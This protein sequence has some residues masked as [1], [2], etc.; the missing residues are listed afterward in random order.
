MPKNMR[1][2]KQILWAL[3]LLLL[4]F[5]ACKE[6]F[7]YKESRPLS[8]NG[9]TYRDT[10]DYQFNITDTS[11]LYNLYLVFEHADTFAWQNL[12]VKL[13]TRFPDGK[14]LSKP[15]SFDFYNNQGKSNG[16]CSG[17]TCVYRSLL[18]GNAFFNVPGAYLLTLEQYMRQDAV[19]GIKKVTFLLEKTKEKR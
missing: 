10:L 5:A 15:C 7:E 16:Q 3:A 9:W 14:R 8:E 2:I 1:G 4:G 11:V 6:P 12:Y 13:Y 19:K 18:Q 17:S